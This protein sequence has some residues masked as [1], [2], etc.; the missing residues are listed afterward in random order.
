MSESPTLT[1]PTEADLVEYGAISPMAIVALLLGLASALALT[2]LL[3]LIVPVIALLVASLAL[4]QIA[5]SEGALIGRTAAIAAIALALLFSSLAI[6]LTVS[7]GAVLRSE[8]QEFGESWMQLARNGELHRAHQ[9]HLL[10]AKRQ[11]PGTSLSHY[12]VNNS[13]AQAD[14]DLL[15]SQPPLKEI[16][17]APEE[18]EFELQN[19][20]FARYEGAEHVILSYE[21]N[22]PESKHLRFNLIVERASTDAGGTWRVVGAQEITGEP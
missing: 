17:A 18:A 14:V 12:Y 1:P 3:L 19:S 9:L 11:L 7:R 15:F 13:E 10:A 5:R 6:S 22:S 8:A 20:Q 21:M 16:I 4:R 2:T